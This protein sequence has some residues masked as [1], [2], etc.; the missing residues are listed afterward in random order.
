MDSIPLDH[1][2]INA[3]DPAALTRLLGLPDLR[4]VALECAE[5]RGCLVLQ[6]VPV[7]ASAPCPTCHQASARLH[8]VA[9]RAVR[10]LPWSR[11]TCYL[12]LRVRRFWCAR[13]RCPFTEALEA[14]APYA[15]LTRRY[16]AHVV[17]A[18]RDT[19]LQQVACREEL[20]YKVVQ[21][22]YYQAVAADL[23]AQPP[24][25]VRRLGI[26]EIAL[27]KGHR[28]FALVVSDLDTKRVL[29]VLAD[30]AQATLEDYLNSWTDAQRA[31]VEE[32]ALD[33]WAPYHSAVGRV[34]PQARRVADRFHVM[35]HL[36]T[37]VSDARRTLQ[38]AAPAAV[39]AQLKGCRWLL[40]KNQAD[41]S[42]EEAAALAVVYEQ[43]P[44]LG[45]VHAW[46]ESFRAIFE[47]AP[48][49]ASAA[50]R[51]QDWRAT[52]A[53]A[54]S[55]ALTKFLGTLRN[56]WEEILNYWP[57]R[58]SSGAVEGLNNKL[59]LIKR[60]A[61]GYRNFEHFRLRVLWECDGIAPHTIAP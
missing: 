7:A 33:L 17:A 27:K 20:G 44:E 16:A 42:A 30:R 28:D 21:R 60:R 9:R 49:R 48:D 5:W 25:L 10:D 29:A 14:V 43:A 2:Q 32:V 15:R 56:W 8:P 1:W 53:A 4:V 13:C 22:A 50:A 52:V 37:A 36:T 3:A 31:A 45:Q 38:R 55:G 61:F 41:L 47:T 11:Y 24:P 34:L 51:L 23:A 46:K 57:Q 54:V 6:C 19:P 59:K 35:K 58:T 26:D 18:C 12:E 40:V 39:R